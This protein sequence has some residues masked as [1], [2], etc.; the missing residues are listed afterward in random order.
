MS[1]KMQTDQMKRTKTKREQWRQTPSE[2]L[3]KG[4][5]KCCKK[6]T[7]VKIMK[8]TMIRMKPV[9]QWIVLI[10]IRITPN[11]CTFSGNP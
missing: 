6:M 3:R 10:I 2:K 1:S 11:T 5:Y 9:G 8:T 4:H 7:N